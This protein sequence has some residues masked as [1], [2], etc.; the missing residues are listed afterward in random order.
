MG[1]DAVFVGLVEDYY[2]SG[3]AFWADSVLTFKITDRARVLKPLLLGKK[4]P[5]VVLADTSGNMQSL[6]NVNAKYTVLCFWDPDCSHCKKVVPKLKEWYAANK[7]KG[8]EVFAA[9]TETEEQKWKKFIR[10]NQLDWINVADIQLRNHFRSVYD[11]SSTPVI[12]MLD[13][14]KV[15]F[16]K[17][18][19]VEQ[20]SEILDNQIKKEKKEGQNKP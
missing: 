19:G 12:Y 3:Q 16:A 7:N 18:M 6:W 11:I 8:I 9:C 2:K 5:N 10:D 13:K 4:A 1:M 17:K 15:I 20:M 14:N